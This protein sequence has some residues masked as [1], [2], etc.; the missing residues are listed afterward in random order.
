MKGAESML[1][2]RNKS[3]TSAEMYISGS[4]VDDDVGG[5]FESWDDPGTGFEWPKE[6]RE[7]LDA[8]KGKDI[9]IYINSDGG[10]VNAGVAIANMISRHDGHTKAVVD[11]WCCSIATQIFFAADE[12]KIPSNAYLMIHKPAVGVYG[13][14]DDLLKVAD[15]LD[16]IQ[17][18]L[19]TTYRKAARDGVTDEEIHE[20]TNKETWLTGTEAAKIFDIELMEPLKA[21][22]CVGNKARFRNTPE[23]IRFM[24]EALPDKKPGQAIDEAASAADD[25]AEVE[26]ALALSKGAMLK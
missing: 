24:A 19:E 11:G 3:D 16:T 1:K 17:E 22:A 7:Q 23:G 15:T 9:T 4:I 8:L 25:E 10:V 13:N 2:I 12:R 26:I 14:S 6:I 20:L 5:Y 18:G 21:V